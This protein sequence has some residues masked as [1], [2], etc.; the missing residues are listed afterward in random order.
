M[1]SSPLLRLLA[2]ILVAACRPV[3]AAEPDRLDAVV[4]VTRDGQGGCTG[5]LV[6]DGLVL[7]A[8]HCV[9]AA[10]GNWTP[11]ATTAVSVRLGNQSLAVEEVTLAPRP[12]FSPTGALTDLGNDWALL[13]VA[14][15]EAKEI[16]P[17]TYL[18]GLALP[19]AF[20]A[21]ERV[22]KVARETAPDG[23][24]IL[25]V[26][27]DCS[28]VGMQP[29]RRTVAFRCGGGAGRGRSGSALL[30]TRPFGLAVL[31]IQ[32]AVSKGS[33]GEIGIGV[34][35]PKARIPGAG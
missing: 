19:A 10:D 21:G 34:V 3:A 24:L 26:E 22:I 13:R 11:A 5:V 20:Q 35:V 14:N 7:T 2:L 4:H 23:G 15:R 8:G 33:G 16:Q 9:T 32:S 1:L 25:A 6:G 12:P 18:G 28:L 29:D 30:L 31:A 27:Q 17:L